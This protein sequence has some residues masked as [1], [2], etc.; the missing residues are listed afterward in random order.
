M[1]GTA[2][3]DAPRLREP[4]AGTTFSNQR[5]RIPMRVKDTLQ[6]LGDGLEKVGGMA[7]VLQSVAS[8]RRARSAVRGARLHGRHVYDEIAGAGPREGLARLASDRFLQEEVAAM[9]RS[10]TRAM[11]V[12]MK[13]V[14]R[15]RKRRR[16]VTVLAGGFVVAGLV[17]VRRAARYRNESMV[18]G[19]GPSAGEENGRRQQ[20]T[21]SSM[22]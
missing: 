12:T 1:G 4:Q 7:G 6:P 15:R 5:R 9:I 19:S 10:A 3:R 13:A 20:A 18:T 14:R 8:D 2:E 16:A 22:T 11:D 21:A 17:A